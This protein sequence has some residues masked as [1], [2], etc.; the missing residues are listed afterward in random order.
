MQGKMINNDVQEKERVDARNALEEYVYD[1]RGKLQEGGTLF[2]YVDE[3]TRVQM[4]NQLD[5][6]EN[7]LYE[8]GESC[9]REIYK[10]KLSEMSLKTT[11]I[12]ARHDEYEGQGPA[13]NDLGHAIQMAYKAVQLYR[14]NDPKYDHLTETEML[15]IS[16]A[17]DKTQ[18]WFQDASSKMRT[19]RRTEDPLV[20][21]ADIRHECQTITACVNSVINRPKPRPPTPPKAE[22]PPAPQDNG[23]AQPEQEGQEQQQQQQNT[24]HST[25]FK[26][27]EMDVD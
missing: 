12:Q 4:C 13:F 14:S 27:G 26:D 10:T 24:S 11:A 15:N 9:E 8:D 22:N 18:K 19:I 7:W 16:E 20:K 23:A 5:E 17:A 25:S 1:M 3:T 2:E 21:L 6:V